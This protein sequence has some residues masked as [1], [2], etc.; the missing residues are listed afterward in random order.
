[1]ISVLLLDFNQIIKN[2]LIT[3]TI[4]FHYHYHSISFHL[5]KDKL[6]EDE[7]RFGHILVKEKALFGLVLGIDF[8]YSQ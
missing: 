2:I 4:L 8:C 5:I 3:I 1:M 6:N 7:S